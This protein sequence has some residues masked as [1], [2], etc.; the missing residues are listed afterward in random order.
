MATK[1]L[2]AIFASLLI[3]YGACQQ[4]PLRKS[5]QEQQ[6]RLLQVAARQP[7]R[8]LESEGGRL[9]MWDENEQQFRCAGVAAFR[10]VVQPNSLALPNFQTSPRLVYILQGEGILGMSFTGC[11][12]TYHS[13]QRG[14]EE[15]AGGSRAE[16]MHQKVHRIRK[17]DIVAVPAGTAHWCY[18]DGSETM[19][20]VAVHDLNNQANQMDQNLR[21]FFLA[22]GV[23]RGLTQPWLKGGETIQNVL[24]AFDPELMAESF[25]VSIDTMSRLQKED[26]RGFIVRVERMKI[27]RPEEEEEF[28]AGEEHERREKQENRFERT[29]C[30]PRLHINL[31]ARRE[32]DVFSR[33]AGRLTVVNE[34]KL[35]FLRF[36]GMSAEKGHLYPN[37]IYS[38]HWAN[39][40]SVVYVTRGSA[41]VQLVGSRGQ[42]VMD[43]RVGE[44]DMFVI[45]QFF[46]SMCRAGSDGF[47]FVS[48]KTTSS[49][50][51]SHTVGR[52]SVLKAMP[53]QVI[54]NSYGVSM[55]EAYGIKQNRGRQHVFLSPVRRDRS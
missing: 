44:G 20:A 32:T 10:I 2:L 39:S 55:S 48:I 1:L 47:E 40:H 50:M 30:N 24:A 21:T 23:P 35:P 31:D 18:N 17:G 15:Q 38:P 3:S 54:A 36:I 4:Q 34:Q 51:K 26:E 25:G 46:A 12:E 22:G 8:W 9:E 43:D 28:E 42:T 52:T 19:V 7:S 29:V 45:P 33:Q 41:R 5:R 6:C 27:T 13:S 37:A 49:P 11:P 16:D 53:L 14:G